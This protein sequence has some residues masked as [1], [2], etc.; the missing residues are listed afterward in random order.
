MIA[1]TD[2]QYLVPTSGGPLRGL[3]Q[4]HVV[5]GVWMCNKSTYFTRD[6]YFQIIY[7]ALRTENGYTGRSRIETLPPAIMKPKTLW[8]GKQ[9]VSK[10]DTRSV[11][12][13]I[14]DLHDHAQS[15]PLECEGIELDFEE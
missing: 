4:D 11:C 1:N 9:L 2:N 14:L 13:L 10:I 12:E 8:T 5:A 15:Y 3:I 6:Q 7:G